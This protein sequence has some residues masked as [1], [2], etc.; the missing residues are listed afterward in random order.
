M[1][2]LVAVIDPSA[3]SDPQHALKSADS[4]QTT[5]GLSITGTRMI[6]QGDIGFTPHFASRLNSFR[7]ISPTRSSLDALRMLANV[8]GITATELNYPQHFSGPADRTLITA[9]RSMGLAVTALN[10][11]F[12]PPQFAAG[13]LTHP[14]SQVRL[15]AIRLAH[16]ALAIAVDTGIDH[17]ILWLGPDGFDY[18]FQAN[19]GALWQFAIEGVLAIAKR[20]PG[21]KVSIEPK[22][23]EPRRH[24]LV[25][26][27]SDALQI[28]RETG[29][30]N[31][32]VTLDFC[33]ALMAGESPAMAAAMAL[34][35]N[36]L[37]GVHLND[38]YGTADDG[39]T[40][41]AVHPVQTL[42]LLWVL[43]SAGWSGTIYFDT[44]PGHADP[45]LECAANISATRSLIASLDRVNPEELDHIQS[46]QDAIGAARFASQLLT[47]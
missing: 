21:V 11:R 39:M 10:L 15:V 16:E 31:V 42:E 7:S 14:D 19:L 46:Q 22:P 6:E 45:S 27:T 9:A 32:G 40:A 2:A 18:P 17:V 47:Q 4:M 35:D 33:H 38:G 29:L 12:D 1:L 37:F 5:T 23:S 43:R 3:S 30:A 28:V 41:G 24:S 13:S 8:P 44:F 25:R 34:R 36:R 26:G 20:E